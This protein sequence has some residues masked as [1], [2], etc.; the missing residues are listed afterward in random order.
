MISR[1]DVQDTVKSQGLWLLSK[2]YKLELRTH[3]A[4]HKRPSA[5]VRP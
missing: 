5:A 1:S 2:S 4:L 3:V